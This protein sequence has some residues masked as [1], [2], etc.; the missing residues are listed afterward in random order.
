M[1]G[2]KRKMKYDTQNDHIY[3]AN[4]DTQEGKGGGYQL[5]F[6]LATGIKKGCPMQPGWIISHEEMLQ[7]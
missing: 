4:Q 5:C 3:C 7:H 2:E 6:T 1:G